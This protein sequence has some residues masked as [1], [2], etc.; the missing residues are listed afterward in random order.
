MEFPSFAR[1]PTPQVLIHRQPDRPDSADGPNRTPSK[2]IILIIGS[3]GSA[4]K[5][6]I[7]Q[8]VSKALS[9]PLFQGDALHESAA[10]AANV[11]ASRAAAGQATDSGGVTSANKPNKARYQRLWLGKLTRTGLLFPDESRPATEGFIGFGG[12]S[13]TST[14]RR[15]SVSSVASESSS[16][17]ARPSSSLASSSSRRESTGST[18]TQPTNMFAQAAAPPVHNPV[19]TLSMEERLRKVNPALLV[20]THPELESWHQRAIREAVCDYKIGVIFVPLDAET[21]D[22]GEDSDGEEDLPVLRP[23]DP[24]SMTSFP[25]SFDAF[26]KNAGTQATLDKEMKLRIDVQADVEGKIDEIVDGVKHIMG[27]E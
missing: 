5:V 18:S 3:T 24:T 8:T 10:K 4:G 16:H 2:Y 26:R 23:L 9:C 12:A 14:S 13:S 11:G 22:D 25:T 15:G 20:L 21:C 7:A 1:P 19:F 27:A 17:L 6:Q